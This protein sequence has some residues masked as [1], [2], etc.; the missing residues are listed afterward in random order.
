M[1]GTASAAL[2]GVEFGSR[3]SSLGVGFARK[4]EVTER[5]VGD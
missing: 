3:E 4:N 2:A 5:L 1:S